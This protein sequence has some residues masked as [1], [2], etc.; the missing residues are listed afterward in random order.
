MIV[1]QK[2]LNRA[3]KVELSVSYSARGVQLAQQEHVVSM[4]MTMHV[5]DPHP[6]DVREWHFIL[7]AGAVNGID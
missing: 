4:S 7:I 1:I 6:V 2:I 5:S 3:D